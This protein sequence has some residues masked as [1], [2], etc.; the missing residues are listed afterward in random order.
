MSVAFKGYAP[1]NDP[2]TPGILTDCSAL[3]P[4]LKGMKGAPSPQTRLLPA[5]AAACRGSAVLRKIDNSTRLFAGTATALYEEATNAWTT[6]T[7]AVG[8]AYAL[9]T[10]NRW[11]FAQR[12]DVSFAAAKSDILQ[13]SSAG[14]FANNAANAPKASIV[15]VANGYIILFDVNDQGAIYDSTDRPQ[16]WWAAKTSG[17]WTPSIANQAFTGELTSTPGKITAGRQ[18]GQTVI[19]YKESSMYMGVL[20]GQSGW[21]FSLIPGGAGALSHEVVVDVGTS[22][23]PVHLSMGYEDFYRYDGSRPV[24]IG[25]PLKE[26]VFGH[27]NRAFT[28]ACMALHDREN[29]RVYFFYPVQGSITPD[30]CVVYNYQT[31]RWGRDDRTVQAVVEFVAVGVTYDDL[32]TLYSTYDDFPT[33][34][35]DKTFLVTGDPLPAIFNTSNVLQ[36]LDG[37]TSDSTMTTGDYG[38][39]EVLSTLTRVQPEFLTRP[40]GTMTNYYRD[41]IGSALTQ[42]Q[43]VSMDAKGRFDVLRSANWHRATFAFSG[44]VEMSGLRAELQEDGSE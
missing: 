24:S 26:T 41:N 22:D 43:Q 33:L 28:H 44:N 19:A 15:E 25:N 29:S 11:R 16:G 1:D 31:D 13:S 38:S 18:F 8:G 35:Y 37:N 12:G 40:T 42:D 27:L 2:K 7:R 9:G 5:L 10:T 32:G 39:D 4:S 30:R 34:S 20:V 23:N 17:T 36:T 14:A 6:V 3:V 21:E